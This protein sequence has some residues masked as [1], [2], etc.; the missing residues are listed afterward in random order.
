MLAAHS[1]D[2]R[3]MALCL[4]SFTA[5]GNIVNFSLDA[6]LAPQAK[7]LSQLAFQLLHGFC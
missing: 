7:P 5:G 4:Q 2:S 1:L 3:I 6:D